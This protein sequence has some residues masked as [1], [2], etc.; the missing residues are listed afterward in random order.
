MTNQPTRPTKDKPT[1]ARFR[2]A[3]GREFRLRVTVDKLTDLAELGLDLNGEP[4]G[5]LGRLTADPSALA[6]VAYEL[7]WPRGHDLTP[8]DFG[9]GIDGDALGEMADALAHATIDFFPSE[10][11]RARLLAVWL[12]TTQQP[13]TPERS[14]A[15]TSPG[16][17]SNS[18]DSAA[19][20]PPG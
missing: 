15:P 2:D 10:T 4:F 11:T 9:S 16:T 8:A 19:S 20:I 1:R 6:T 3:L 17:A 14:S 13:E 7:L 12:T 5:D 18:P